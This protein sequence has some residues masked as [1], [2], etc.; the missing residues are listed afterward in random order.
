MF[1]T[2]E[3]AEDLQDRRLYSCTIRHI[4]RLLYQVQSNA[5]ELAVIELINAGFS[6][7]PIIAAGFPVVPEILELV[8][9]PEATRQMLAK[10]Q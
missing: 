8:N 3:G 1:W 4:G 9:D 5:P 7:E 2:T 6:V 10:F